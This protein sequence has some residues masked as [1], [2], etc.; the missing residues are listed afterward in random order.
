MHE[1]NEPHI[2]FDAYALV[3]VNIVNRWGIGSIVGEWSQS[4]GNGDNRW[5]NWD[6][7]WGIGIIVG[8]YW[9]SKYC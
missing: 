9:F 5:G 7:R 8:V 1:L 3:D 4:L 6:N 2:A